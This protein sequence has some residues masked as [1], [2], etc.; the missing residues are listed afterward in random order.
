MPA[1]EDRQGRA[2]FAMG[3][4]ADTP[5][6]RAGGGTANDITRNATLTV[7]FILSLPA[8]VYG[9]GFNLLRDFGAGPLLLTLAASGA[10]ALMARQIRISALYYPFLA[11]ST[12]YLGLSLAGFMPKAWTTLYE[13]DAALRHWLWAPALP[14]L[15]TSYSVLFQT[16][17]RFI[18][19][20]ALIIGL[21]LWA[22]N[23]TVTDI[24]DFGP[25][26]RPYHVTGQAI[27]SYLCL[28]LFVFREKRAAWKDAGIILAFIL[29]AL[30]LSQT[31][32]GL[33]LLTIRFWPRPQWVVNILGAALTAIL[34]ITPA[35]PDQLRDLDS[36]AGVRAV[37]WNDAIDAVL[38]TRGVGVGYGTEYIRNRFYFRDSNEWR[39]TAVREGDRLYWS[40]HATPYDVVMRV[41]L[42]GLA[43]F[44]AWFIGL[45]RIPSKLAAT[46]QRNYA[47]TACALMIYAAFNPAFISFTVVFGTAMLIGW[48]THLRRLA[49]RSSDA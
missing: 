24:T 20:R 12:I 17:W 38:E 22:V 43:L 29:A 15:I 37:M 19:R 33:A 48:M 35:F 14:F 7:A 9:M 34:V 4:A 47:A 5:A 25:K 1:P 45:L 32:F 36:N 13:A 11:L 41:G 31:L 3:E 44:M 2:G 39:L 42:L 6:A 18:M 21:V 16:L 40:T 46:D 26:L 10:C 8:F 49:A 30:S 23:F 27:P 28:I